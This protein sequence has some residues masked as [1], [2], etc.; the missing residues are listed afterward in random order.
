M[1][2]TWGSPD[3]NLIDNIDNPFNN[4]EIVESLRV[5]SVVPTNNDND[6][7]NKEDNMG[8][9]NNTTET[10]D[11]QEYSSN[12]LFAILG[13]RLAACEACIDEIKAAIK[14]YEEAVN[15]KED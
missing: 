5:A 1:S 10:K 14:K 8:T 15:K 4:V 9:E 3:A 13:S 2:K 7:K 12:E 6:I 11:L